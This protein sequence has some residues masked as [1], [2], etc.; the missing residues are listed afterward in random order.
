[1]RA[2]ASRTSHPHTEILRAIYADL[3]ALADYADDDV[4]LHRADRTAEDPGLCRGVQAVVAHERALLRATEDTLVMDVEHI[5]ANDHFGAVLG[6]LRT[7]RPREIAMPFCGLWRFA[8]G[9]IVEHWEN[10]YDV[11]ELRALFTTNGKR[12]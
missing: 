6:V 9:R 7:S 2:A 8:D 4:V 5:T 1:M 3:P 12:P 11:A 10:A